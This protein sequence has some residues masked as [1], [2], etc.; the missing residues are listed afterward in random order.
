MPQL[1]CVF[2]DSEFEGYE[3]EVYCSPDCRASDEWLDA[4]DDGCWMPTD[5]D[6]ERHEAFMR[7]NGWLDVD[8]KPMAKATLVSTRRKETA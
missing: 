3:G 5:D 1:Q 7:M 4:T 6:A 8:R 2:C